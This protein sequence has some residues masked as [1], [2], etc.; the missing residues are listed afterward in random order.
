MPA[1]RLNFRWLGAATVVG[2][3]SMLAMIAL[4]S[5]VEILGLL[6]VRRRECGGFRGEQAVRSSEKSGGNFRC[7]RI[8]SRRGH[9]SPH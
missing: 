4:A 6:A 5:R 8:V 9:R 3:G 2:I 7:L 1:L